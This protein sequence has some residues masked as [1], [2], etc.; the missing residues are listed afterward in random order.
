M[1]YVA[2]VLPMSVLLRIGALL[3]EFFLNPD[4][5]NLVF[6]SANSEWMYGLWSVV[7][8]L[9]NIFLILV[10]LLSAFSTIF[11]IQKWHLKNTLLMIVLMAL[12]VN[13]SWPITRMF[14]DMGNITLT[15]FYEQTFQEYHPPGDQEKKNP[16]AIEKV[17]LDAKVIEIFVPSGEDYKKARAVDMI[18]NG[19]FL[20]IFGMIFIIMGV[21]FLLRLVMFIILLIVSPIGFIAAAFPSTRQYASN[22]WEN[23]LK[24]TFLAPIM[25]FMLYLS[26]KM[27]E[28]MQAANISGPTT[29]NKDIGT[30]AVSISRA[31]NYLAAA[32]ILWAG[33]IAANKLGGSAATFVTKRGTK[34]MRWSVG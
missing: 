24:W 15:Y 25:V 20:F 4:I 1:L 28:G 19:L 10:L 30:I 33:I 21:L 9:L 31:V 5:F 8:D 18:F 34:A 17:A 22:W 11:Q 3:A 29:D 6:N 23:M 27:I 16:T 14:I 26:L 7:R 2:W 12:L 13:F 32:V